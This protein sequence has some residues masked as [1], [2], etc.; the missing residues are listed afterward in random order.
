MSCGLTGLVILLVQR[1]KNQEWMRR[2][3]FAE[4]VT[5]GETNQPL[6]QLT[7]EFVEALASL[8]LQGY[9]KTACTVLDKSGFY[10]SLIEALFAKTPAT[11]ADAPSSARNYLLRR[12]SSGAARTPVQKIDLSSLHLSLLHH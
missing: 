7:L 12:D 1:I 4:H 8:A 5:L 2:K 10:A 3:D 11:T 6:T 9:S